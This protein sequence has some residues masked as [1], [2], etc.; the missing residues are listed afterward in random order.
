M[1]L[2]LRAGDRVLALGARPLLMGVVNASPDSFSDGGRWS[3]VEEQLGLAR[4]LVDAGADVLD[5]GGESG[6]TN[7]P[8]V[9]PD[10]EIERVVPLIERI[11]AELDVLIAVDTYTPTVAA[12]AIAAGAGMIND[13]SG[14]RDVAVAEVC[15][16]TGAALVIAYTRAEPKVKLLDP[17]WDGRVVQDAHA[18]LAERMALAGAQGVAAEQVVLD[19]GPDLGKTPEQ[20]VELLRELRSFHA[21][22][23]PLLLAVSR[24]DF[25]GVVTGRRPSERGAATLA[26]VAHG[27]DAGAGIL[28][29]HDVAATADFVAV[30]AVLR[31]DADV[32]PGARL[33]EDLRRE[34][35][36]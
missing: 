26:A 21:L 31:G 33:A 13:V 9:A 10:V 29:V 4:A 35:A 30:R 2:E 24:K 36:R 18:F 23:R 22:G 32:P 28:R 17:S 12:A 15:G 19:P 27:L 14:L 20:T 11:A 5:V 1:S 16:R 3:T 6:V 7:R 25:L 34:P 8:A